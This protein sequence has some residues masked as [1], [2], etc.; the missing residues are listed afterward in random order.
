MARQTEKWVGIDGWPYEVSD[1]GRVRRATPAPRTRPGFVLKQS[2]DGNGYLRVG[3]RRDGARLQKKFFVAV[4][5]AEAFLGKRAPGKTVNHINGRKPDNRAENLEWVTR[6]ENQKHAYATGLQGKGQDHG[7]ARLS[8]ED[9]REI[10]RRYAARECSQQALANEY[11]V[12]QALV[13]QIT[14]G[15][16]WTHVK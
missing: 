6:S 1:L 2:E 11:M 16:I 9:V 14:R 8:D 7:M 10:R 15:K 13:S 12:S 5:V 4:L 3:L